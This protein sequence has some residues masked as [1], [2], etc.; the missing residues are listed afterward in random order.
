MFSCS[1]S[2][3]SDDYVK[4]LQGGRKVRRL[5][6]VYGYGLFGWGDG[7]DDC[8]DD[9]HD[10]DGDDKS[11]GHGYERSKKMFGYPG[12]SRFGFPMRSR[13]VPPYVIRVYIQGTGEQISIIFKS[14]DDDDTEKGFDAVY[15]VSKGEVCQYLDFTP[16]LF[17]LPLPSVPFVVYSFLPFNL[18]LEIACLDLFGVPQLGL[19]III[20]ENI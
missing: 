18:N 5:S 13:Y 10:G 11:D 6:G 14:D 20:I 2:F 16:L 17:P 12:G 7:D 9:D 4:I 15:R 1:C 3:P 19:M 8:D